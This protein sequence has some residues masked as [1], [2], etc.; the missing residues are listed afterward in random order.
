[1]KFSETIQHKIDGTKPKRQTDP[2]AR[3]K[4]IFKKLKAMEDT[5]SDP[6][7]FEYGGRKFT[8]IK[9]F[10]G[11]EL[12][13]LSGNGGKMTLRII[14]IGEVVPLGYVRQRLESHGSV[15]FYTHD[16][17]IRSERGF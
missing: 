8:F 12:I 9:R 11:S 7:W 4:R 14:L 1:M 6:F 5:A 3:H 2:L 10:R 15:D 17:S 16:K 13:H